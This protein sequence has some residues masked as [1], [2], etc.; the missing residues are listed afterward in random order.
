MLKTL[1]DDNNLA[2]Y[3][4]YDS[5]DEHFLDTPFFNDF[6][7]DQRD[8]IKAIEDYKTKLVTFKRELEQQIQKFLTQDTS[9]EQ[10]TP[11]EQDPSSEQDTSLSQEERL[12]N[13]F[14]KLYA[15]YKIRTTKPKEIPAYFECPISLDTIML[16]VSRIDD[17]GH[18]F[19]Y[20][21]SD[22]MRALT[23]STKRDNNDTYLSPEDP[24]TRAKVSFADYMPD[25]IFDCLLDEFI[26]DPEAYYKNYDTTDYQ[27]AHLQEKRGLTKDEMIIYLKNAQLQKD[28]GLTKNKVITFYAGK[29][30]TKQKKQ[31]NKRIPK[32]TNKRIPKQTN[33]RR[34]K[35]TNKRRQKQTNKR[36]QKQTNKR[37]KLTL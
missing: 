34:Q 12:R 25:P 20:E 16:P 37:K 10:D 35:Q 4:M 31:T 1:L 27:N 5:I 2:E 28:K 32:Q 36:R 9:S 22:I 24:Q 13:E 3:T 26:I 18:V 33:K 21:S 6:I 11:S 15:N 14:E 30:K 23:E 17:K 8:G 7:K 19:T 29:R